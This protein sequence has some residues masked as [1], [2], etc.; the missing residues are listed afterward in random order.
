MYLK[1][2]NLLRVT[3]NGEFVS[4]YPGAESSRVLSAIEK[5]GTIWPK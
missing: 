5:G 3:N 2:N 1:G 4:L